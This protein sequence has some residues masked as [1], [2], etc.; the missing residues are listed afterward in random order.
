MATFSHK[1]AAASDDG[2]VGIYDSVTGVLRLSINLVDPVQAIGGSPDG[3]ILF[4]AHNTPSVTVWDMQTGGLIRTFDLEWNA[5]DIAVSLKG[6]Y[7]ACRSSDGHGKVLRVASEMGGSVIWTRSSVTRFCWLE[8]EEQLV[9]STGISVDVVDITAGTVLRHFVTP[10]SVNRVVYSQKFNRLAIV[11]SS[12]AK[13]VVAVINPQTD[14]PTTSHWVHTGSNFSCLAFSRTTEELVCGTKAHGLQVFNI[15]R[16]IVRRLEYSNAVTSLSSL[17]NGTVVANVAGSRIQLLSLDGWHAPSQQSTISALTVQDF[18]QGKII[19]I[20]TTDRE[21]VV[22]LETASM[23]KLLKIPVRETRLTPT[24]HSTILC[25]SHKKSMAVYY[26]KVDGIMFLE[27]WRFHE[28]VPRWFV[29]VGGAP[30]TGRFSP[31]AVRFVTLHSMHHLSDVYVWTS[32][33]RI[34]IGKLTQIP[35]PLDIKFV[36]DTEFRLYYDDHHIPYTVSPSGGIRTKAISLPH[37]GSSEPRR[38]LDVDDTHEWVVSGSVKVSWIP[39]GY[40]GS[41][42]HSYCWSRSS[43]I[44]AGQDGVLRKLTFS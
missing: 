11:T 35:T 9:V 25:A 39:T 44:M 2:M 17:Q 19:A 30:K 40:I 18:D 42:K 34:P 36:S 21:H 16:R 28:A 20:I 33:N 7:L 10:Y 41:T 26:F 29:E 4:C 3:S 13:S 38:C 8:P 12:D 24:D 32:E 43:L 37:F 31:T 1:I 6:C 23:S 27:L 22:L 15:S 5:Q 14:I